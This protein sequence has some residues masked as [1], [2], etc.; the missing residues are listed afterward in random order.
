MKNTHRSTLP[1]AIAIKQILISN[2]GICKDRIFHNKRKNYR[3]V[4]CYTSDIKKDGIALKLELI[5]KAFN[6]YILYRIDDVRA[7]CASSFIITI[8]DCS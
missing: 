6:V 2:F 1:A 3:T 4:K 5:A 8:S 7:G